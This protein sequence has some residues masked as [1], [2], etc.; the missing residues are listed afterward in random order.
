ML[1]YVQP[2]D[3]EGFYPIIV[4]SS[5]LCNGKGCIVA[6]GDGEIRYFPGRTMWQRAKMLEERG[7][8]TDQWDWDDIHP[9][10]KVN[11]AKFRVRNNANLE[12]QILLRQLNVE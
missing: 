7:T 11:K 10:F 5:T 1:S 4:A 9:D 6:H 12:A 3:D 8:G 2:R